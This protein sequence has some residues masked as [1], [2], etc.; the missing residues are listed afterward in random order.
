MSTLGEN[1]L[2]WRP[3]EE[4]LRLIQDT[5]PATPQTVLIL[6]AGMAGLGAAYEL[7]RNPGVKHVHVVEGRRHEG[8]VVGVGGRVRTHRFGDAPGPDEADTRPYHELGAMRIPHVTH[9]YTWHYVQELCL[10]RRPFVNQVT[11]FF[12]VR[13]QKY[14]NNGDGRKALARVFQ[15]DERETC[16]VEKDGPAVLLSMATKLLLDRLT[17]D[18]RRMLVACQ[19]STPLLRWLDAQT[20]VGYL[21]TGLPNGVSGT[22]IARPLSANA[23]ALLCATTA[24]ESRWHWSLAAELRG[25]LTNTPA[26]L[27]EERPLWEVEGGLDRLPRGLYDELTADPKKKVTFH[28]ETEVTKIRVTKDVVRVE[29]SQGGEP[30][31][32]PFTYDRVICTLPFP[33]LRQLELEGLSAAKLRAIRN[34]QLCSST[35]VLLLCKDRFWEDQGIRGGSSVTDRAARQAY[36]PSDFARAQEVS[37]AEPLALAA[38]DPG[39]ALEYWNADSPVGAAEPVG[40][41]GASLAE[42]RSSRAGVLLGSYTWSDAARQVGRLAGEEDAPAEAGP[43]ASRRARIVADLEKLH[44]ELREKV[45]D[46]ASIYWD[47]DK[48]AK[49]AFGSTPPGDLTDYYQ[50]GRRPEGRLFFAGEHIS[51]APGWI[52]GALESGLDAAYELL[53]QASKAEAD[54][55]EPASASGPVRHHIDL[56]APLL[57]IRCRKGVLGC[58]YFDVATFDKT[59][60]AGV[61]IRGV[62]SLDDLLCKEVVR[63]E[64]I[65]EAAQHLGVRPGMTGHQVIDRLS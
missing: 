31:T 37:P 22:A 46:S 20:L 33:V 3:V 54:D 61:V 28:F 51:I 16:A 50:D 34:L 53:K 62:N 21:M 59:K 13:G 39:E 38:A 27:N 32:P 18:E 8:P 49:G 30:W 24:L 25:V 17:S 41:E 7:A 1:K 23:R 57:F 35:K 11:G 12:E 14:P 4:T 36:Y 45:C 10:N 6:G 29:F 47:R 19:L 2:L 56:G 43:P 48:W 55:A 9:D 65:S 26:K 63:R 52:Q 58:G 42:G 5:K 44:P 64:D 40:S 60:E 15:L